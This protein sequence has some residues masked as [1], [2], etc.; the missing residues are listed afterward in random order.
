MYVLLG[1]LEG[2]RGRMGMGIEGQRIQV[3]EGSAV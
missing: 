1:R 2:G 3:A